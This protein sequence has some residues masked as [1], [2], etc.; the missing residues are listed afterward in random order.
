MVSVKPNVNK[1]TGIVTRF[2]KIA[3]SL[4]AYH[5][6]FLLATLRLGDSEMQKY[7]RVLNAPLMI[8]LLQKFTG[9]PCA[10]TAIH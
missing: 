9:C 1:G 10:E 6:S 4:R 5:F 7:D 3:Q 2:K 8:Y